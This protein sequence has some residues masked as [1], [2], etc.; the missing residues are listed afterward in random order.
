MIPPLVIVG[1]LNANN[2][3]TY[4]GPWFSA[5][6][7]QNNTGDFGPPYQNSL[8]GVNVNADIF[9]AFNGMSRLL[10]WLDFR[11]SGP[12]NSI[13]VFRNASRCFRDI[14]SLWSP[15]SNMGVFSRR[16]KYWRHSNS[17]AIYKSKQ[18]GNLLGF[19]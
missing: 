7:T 4:S 18:Q 15:R 3:I 9:F 5:N 10:Y 19:C 8:K 16:I 14:H 12:T 2:S 1:N 17:S 13:V 11:P 6:G